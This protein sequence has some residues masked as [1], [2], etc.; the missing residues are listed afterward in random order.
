MNLK[1]KILGS[2]WLTQAANYAD[3]LAIA[4]AGPAILADLDMDPASF[5]IVLSSFGIG[6]MIAHI[7]GGVL[8]DRFGVRGLLIITPLLWALF[9]GLT[10]AMSAVA[11]FVAMRLLLGLSEG[12]SNTA[13]MKAVAD[14]FPPRERP[15]AM[16]LTGTGH[17]IGPALAAP[18]IGLLIALWGWR[19][20]FLVMMIPPILA[21][22]AN[23]YAFPTHPPQ[24][25]EPG[26]GVA[27]HRPGLLQ[28]ARMPSMWL[29]VFVLFCFGIGYWGFLTWMPTYLA[30]AQGVAVA[31]VGIYASLPFISAFV[32][33]LA[34]GWFGMVAQ[35]RRPLLA[36]ICYVG[37]SAAL[38]LSIW[39]HSL[40]AIIAGLCLAGFFLAGSV[41]LLGTIVI[42][43]APEKARAA[44]SGCVITFGHLGGV[45]APAIIGYL[46]SRTGNFTSA[47]AFMEIMLL[48]AAGTVLLVPWL[49][50]RTRPA[51]EPA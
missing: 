31:K 48:A 11:G 13:Y 45:L 3:R 47:F 18:L 17:T 24:Q 1:A 30:N 12:A 5:G 22:I 15:G 50:R 38:F 19:S 23:R 49:D 2:L 32:G 25:A 46:V 51:A 14:Y 9:T 4:I 33:T 35:H 36:A 42:E 40:P 6:F 29:L 28:L 27:E 10:G 16:A 39:S 44:F 37:A 7:P 43:V 20:V 21:A 41:P 8:A 34:W 26:E